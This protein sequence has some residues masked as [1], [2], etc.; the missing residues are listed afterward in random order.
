MDGTYAL[1]IAIL[2]CEI[3]EKDL[4]EGESL[5]MRRYPISAEEAFKCYLGKDYT[6]ESNTPEYYDYGEKYR[7]P[8][9]AV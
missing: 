1:L 3:K 9:E 8:K 2:G 5:G 7:Y 6:Y 4:D